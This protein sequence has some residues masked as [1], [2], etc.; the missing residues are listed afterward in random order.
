MN[1]TYKELAALRVEFNNLLINL[2]EQ[3]CNR[4]LDIIMEFGSEGAD[5]DE[6]AHI[7]ESKL[8][9]AVLKTID[10]PLA[11]L[12]LKTEEISFSRWFA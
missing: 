7:L 3:K 12:A 10:H 1:K 4:C 6:V 8:R 5:D 2:D 11:K 9:E